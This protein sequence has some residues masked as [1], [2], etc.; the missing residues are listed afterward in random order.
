MVL[1]ILLGGYPP[2]YD[3]NE[4]ALFAQI[5]RGAFSFDDP[6]WD[7]VSDKCAA[8]LFL[9]SGFVLAKT[10]QIWR[11]AL[12]LDDPARHSVWDKCAQPDATKSSW[13]CKVVAELARD[14]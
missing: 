9:V 13:V 4:P 10:A 8:L 7:S 6:V 14:W 1:F 11:G 2:F 3:E 5:R 12:S